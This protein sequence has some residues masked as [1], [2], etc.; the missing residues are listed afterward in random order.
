MVRGRGR[1]RSSWLLPTHLCM[2]DVAGRRESGRDLGA[3]GEVGK[4]SPED[5][6]AGLV[7][8]FSRRS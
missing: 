1:T 4:M 6:G 7:M 3:F 8:R 5:E 2:G